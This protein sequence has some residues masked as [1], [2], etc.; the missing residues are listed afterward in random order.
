MMGQWPL[1][2]NAVEADTITFWNQCQMGM[3]WNGNLG[4]REVTE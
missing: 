2:Q 4:N 1:V 3:S